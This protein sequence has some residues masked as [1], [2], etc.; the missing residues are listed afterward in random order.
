[1]M[2]TSIEFERFNILERKEISVEQS[3]NEF[4]FTKT[5]FGRV[6]EVKRE[7]NC[8]ILFLNDSRSINFQSENIE[9]VCEIPSSSKQPQGLQIL[10]KNNSEIKIHIK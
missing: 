5:S 6:L 8:V 4:N 7:S 2:Y 1:M 10:F 9:E 3:S